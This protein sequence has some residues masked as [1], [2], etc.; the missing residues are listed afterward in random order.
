[1]AGPDYVLLMVTGSD[2]SSI[3]D[4]VVRGFQDISDVCLGSGAHDVPRQVARPAGFP[5]RETADSKLQTRILE[6]EPPRPKTAMPV[7]QA[8][9]SKSKAFAL[10]DSIGRISAD[11]VFIYPPGSPIIV[12]GER[13][14]E[15]VVE[16]LN[17]AIDCGLEVLGRGYS[18]HQRELKVFCV[19]P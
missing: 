16:Y 1:M 14:S 6:Q 2:D 12:P 19:E 17:A 9:Y 7:A 10:K 5:H 13:I 4:R 3:I 15:S 11:T 18:D 8:F